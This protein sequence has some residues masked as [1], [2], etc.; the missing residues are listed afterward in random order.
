M[1]TCGNDDRREAKEHNEYT[2]GTHLEA[3]NKLV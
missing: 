2:V 1:L 3:D